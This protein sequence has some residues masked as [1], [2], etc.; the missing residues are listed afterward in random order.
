VTAITFSLGINRQDEHPNV[1]SDPTF[2][3]FQ[4]RVLRMRH[5]ATSKDRTPYFARAFRLNGTDRPHRSTAC[6]LPCAWVALDVDGLTPDAATRL[7]PFVARLRGF[8]YATQSA[9]PENLKC[10]IVIAL[11]REASVDEHPRVVDALSTKVRAAVGDGIRLDDAVARDVARLWYLPHQFA[12]DG[13]LDGRP[14]PVDAALAFHSANVPTARGPLPMADATPDPDLIAH[15]LNA[16]AGMV[17]TSLL[18]LSA[19]LAGRGMDAAEI[20]ATLRGHLDNPACALRTVDAETWTKRRAELRTLAASAVRKYGDRRVRNDATPDIDPVTGEVHEYHNDD[21]EPL[22]DAGIHEKSSH[23][24]IAAHMLVGITAAHGGVSPVGVAGQLYLYSSAVGVW[25]G[26]SIDTL[27]VQ[28]GRTMRGSNFKRF[29]DYRAVA[30]IIYITCER[31][32]FFDDAPIG[33]AADGKFYSITPEGKLRTAPL[34]PEHRAR[35]VL[36]AAPNK[37]CKADRFKALLTA[38]FAGDDAVAQTALVQQQFG[39]AVT[40]MMSRLQK[41]ALWMGKTRAGKSTLQNILRALFHPDDVCSVAPSRWGREYHAAALA[42]KRL[43]LVGEI[44]TKDPLD[45]SFKQTTGGDLLQGRHPTHRPFEFV[46]DAAHVFNCNGF[47]ATLDRSDAFFRRWSIVLFRNVCATDKV[48][49][50]LADEVIAN[51]LGFVAWWAL[52]GAGALVLANRRFTETAA[53]TA[54]LEKWRN[55][56]DSVFACLLDPDC[57]A[58]WVNDT[59]STLREEGDRQ[60]WGH[61][62]RRGL[63]QQYRGWCVANGSRPLGLGAYNESLERFMHLYRI[64]ENTSAR[65]LTGIRLIGIYNFGNNRLPNND[66]APDEP[67]AE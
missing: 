18:K 53:H 33:V 39:A 19:R 57:V 16:D 5:T 27:A 15:I 8:W 14:L 28:I 12:A 61:T 51:E 41:V 46:C 45:V 30:T 29:G 56:A 66:L 44:D 59:G 49:D 35:F 7:W 52:A 58:L 24:E 34:T 22:D 55:R 48:N 13:S 10:R 31:M 63:Y 54:T 26:I 21:E 43:N 3:D 17:Y 23:S 2:D 38:A 47:P 1:S 42:G 4:A 67:L 65:L 36:S 6:A 50:A 40:G 32:R 37:D 20:V 60:T 25:N 64:G 11:D 62:T 9:T